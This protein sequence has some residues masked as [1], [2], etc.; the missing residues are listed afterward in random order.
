MT[1]KAKILTIIGLTAA[2][3][4]LPVASFAGT[5]VGVSI[6]IGFP[7]VGFFPP[8][9]VVAVPPVAVVPAPVAVVPAPVAV[10]PA[11]VAVF[12]SPV[13]V[14]PPGVVVRAGGFY[15]APVHRGYWHGGRYWH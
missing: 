1:T 10:Y 14:V 2:A 11:P 4:A 13:Y 7:P 6:G 9:P 12:P 15:G 5:S 8:A 3:T